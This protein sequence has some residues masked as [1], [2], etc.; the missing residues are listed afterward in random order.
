MAAI[1]ILPAGFVQP[2]YLE[3]RSSRPKRPG[4]LRHRH[5]RCDSH[6]PALRNNTQ[7]STRRTLQLP[8]L[9]NPIARISQ[10][11]TPSYLPTA[12]ATATRTLMI[13]EIKTSNIFRKA[14]ASNACF[15]LGF[16]KE[17]KKQGID[18]SSLPAS[19]VFAVFVAVPTLILGNPSQ[20]FSASRANLLLRRLT[21]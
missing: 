14:R 1:S 4:R 16:R 17:N 2:Y 21:P 12:S 7:R 20:R 19:N 5:H 10:L 8:R 3:H 15:C 13:V 11:S 9:P 6:F 18:I